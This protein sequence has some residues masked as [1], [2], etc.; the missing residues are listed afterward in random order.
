VGKWSAVF[1][2]W[3]LVIYCN[4]KRLRPKA[5]TEGLGLRLHN[6]KR[7]HRLRA[8]PFLNEPF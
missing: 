6:H 3:S 1:G 4:E 5:K 7:D 8:R 2:L